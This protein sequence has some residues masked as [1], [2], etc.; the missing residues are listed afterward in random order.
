MNKYFE[1]LQQYFG[2]TSFRPLQEEI[3]QDV[4]AKKDV[5]VLMPTGSGKSLCYQLP[6][7]ASEGVTVVVSPLIALMKDQVDGLQQNGVKAAFLNSSQTQAQQQQVLAAAR[8]GELSLLYLA[9]ERLAQPNFWQTLRGFPLT[10][11]AIDE[12]HCISE[13][14]HD[15]RPEYRQLSV[16]KKE[17]STIPLIA[18]T[19]TATERVQADILI[20]LGLQNAKTYQASFNR[21]NLYYSV[22]PKKDAF[23]QIFDF[24]AEHPQQ[25]GIIYCQSRKKVDG[26]AERLKA[27]GI[28]ALPYHAGLSDE[29]R[30]KNQEAFSRDNV[31]IIVATIAFGMGIDKPNVRFVIHYDLP[32][33][34][35]RYYQETGRAGR[36]SLPSECLLFFSYGDKEA[37]EHFIRMKQDPKEQEIAR[38]Q[39]TQVVRYAEQRQCRRKSL[40][41]YFGEEMQGETCD[42]C[43]NCLSPDPTFDGTTLAQKIIS[44]VVRTGERFGT[45]HVAKVLVGSKDKRVLENEHN[46]LTTYG[47]ITDYSPQQIQAFTRQLAEQG[48]LEITQEKYPIVRLTGK[49]WDVLKNG[50]K[51]VLTQPQEPTELRQESTRP[52]FDR[53]LFAALRVLRK[54]LADEKNVPP[55]IIFS[56]ISLEEMAQYFPQTKEQFSTISGVGK[57]KLDWYGS[58][59]L[60]EIEAY[61]TPRNIAPKS[62]AVQNRTVRTIRKKT[63]PAKTETISHTMEMVRQGLSIEEIAKQRGIVSGTVA[64]HIEK[65]VLA[66]DE[67]TLDRFVMPEKQMVIRKMLIDAAGGPITPIKELLGSAYSFEEIR[68]VRAVM[69][70]ENANRESLMGNE[71]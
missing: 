65:A 23:D 59:F 70:M 4:L 57:Q 38:A 28:K 60:N 62:K 16:V 50:L 12:A 30:R 31:D 15:F 7:I 69:A 51:V 1:I 36:D 67:I 61:C 44:C 24:I 5:F 48:C 22:R 13:W 9:P 21:P 41:S 27:N 43:D 46:K 34:L 47:I 25:S 54:R 63:K 11:F 55:Y 32:A 17:F 42:N 39:L 40:L 37:I 53:E 68:L 6:A 26:I 20:Q 66:G 29:V 33:N 18:L 10:L 71:E 3:I 8:N 52:D 14:G 58:L 19:A 2:Y 45:G 64:S 35:E 49:S 56:D